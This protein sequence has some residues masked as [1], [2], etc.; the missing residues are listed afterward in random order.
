VRARSGFETVLRVEDAGPFFQVQAL[1]AAGSVLGCSHV[2]EVRA[3]HGGGRTDQ[4][5]AALAV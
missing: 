3:P 4:G 2:L 5:P 1:D